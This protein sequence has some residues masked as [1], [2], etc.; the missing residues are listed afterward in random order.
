MYIYLYYIQ[1][2]ILLTMR[3]NYGQQQGIIN[4]LIIA[5]KLLIMKKR[6]V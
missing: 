1:F 5:T 6:T 4:G 2:Y 3:I